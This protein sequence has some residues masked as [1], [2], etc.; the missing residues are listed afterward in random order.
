M[1]KQFLVTLD[2]CDWLHV[3]SF[4]LSHTTFSFVNTVN[5]LLGETPANMPTSSP[6]TPSTAKLHI[7][8]EHHLSLPIRRYIAETVNTQLLGQPSHSLSCVLMVAVESLGVII[9][10]DTPTT[11]EDVCRMVSSV[12]YL[13]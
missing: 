6:S 10:K 13:E 7:P 8:S 4:V 12:H 9:N 1:L 2:C 3:A 5:V 11:L